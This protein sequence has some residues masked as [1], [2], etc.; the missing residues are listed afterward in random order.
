MSVPHA[1]HC[2]A[3]QPI[4]SVQIVDAG[5]RWP[6]KKI[7]GTRHADYTRCAIITSTLTPRARRRFSA[8]LLFLATRIRRPAVIYRKHWSEMVHCSAWQTDSFFL[9]VV[10]FVLRLSLFQCFDG[11]VTGALFLPHEK[12]VVCSGKSVRWSVRHTCLNRNT[13]PNV[14]CHCSVVRPFDSYLAPQI[15]AKI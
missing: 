8:F 9:A 4:N 5:A 7:R 12:H 11:R 1:C 15:V 2:F 14:L 10:P 6:P 3:S 13:T